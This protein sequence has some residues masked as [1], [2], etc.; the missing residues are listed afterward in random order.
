MSDVEVEGISPE[1]ASALIA[2][3]QTFEDLS[4]RAS[5]F[6]DLSDGILLFEI[7]SRISPDCFDLSN[8]KREVSDNWL[9]R[10]ENIRKLITGMKNFYM[11]VLGRTLTSKE[12]TAAK[13]AREADVDETCKLISHLLGCAVQCENKGIF[14]AAIMKLNQAH[15]AQLM[16]VIDEVV[17]ASANMAPLSPTSFGSDEN[18][19]DLMDI[20]G[21]MGTGTEGMRDSFNDFGD[22]DMYTAQQDEIVKLKKDSKSLAARVADLESTNKKLLDEARFYKEQHADLQNADKEKLARD[23]VKEVQRLKTVKNALSKREFELTTELQDV[24]MFYFF[25]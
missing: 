25:F 22:D 7:G 15:Q 12:V 16:L 5:S 2:W 11:D 23:R 3:V 13:I 24:C 8:I 1:M 19:V 14:V 17:N 10:A 18:D 6:S 9:L 21:R 4:S 20:G